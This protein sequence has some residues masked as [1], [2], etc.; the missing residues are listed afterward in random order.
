MKASALSQLASVP[1]LTP[2]F[3]RAARYP[4][5]GAPLGCVVSGKQVPF[6]PVLAVPGE[7]GWGLLWV[8]CWA[9]QGVPGVG[10]LQT[11]AGG[12]GVEPSCEGPGSC[13]S[14]E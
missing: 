8:P 12:A 9:F 2:G 11:R 5:V 14:R 10:A 1:A 13:Q 7:V 4:G 6:G 3:S